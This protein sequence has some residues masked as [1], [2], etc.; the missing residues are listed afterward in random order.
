MTMTE[1]T[2]D[3]WRFRKGV[4]AVVTGGSRGI[5][6]SIVEELSKKGARILTCARTES[7][8][9]TK[10]TEW[11]SKGYQVDGVPADLSTASGRF[12]FADA[13]RTWL[14]GKPLDILVNNAGRQPPLRQIFHQYDDDDVL[15]GSESDELWATNFHSTFMLTS[16]CH[17]HLKRKKHGCSSTSSVVNIASVFGFT[18]VESRSPYPAAQAAVIKA[19]GDWAMDWGS[20]GIR[21][22]CVSPGLIRTGDESHATGFRKN[23]E[24]GYQAQILGATPLSRAGEP[25]EVAGLVTFLCLPISSFITGQVMCVDG[26]YSRSE[27]YNE[28][29]ARCLREK[30]EEI[31]VSTNALRH[32][33]LPSNDTLEELCRELEESSI[34]ESNMSEDAMSEDGIIMAA[35]SE[36]AISE[37]GLSDASSEGFLSFAMSPSY[38]AADARWRAWRQ[39]SCRESRE[40]NTQAR[41]KEQS[42]EK[43]SQAEEIRPHG[44]QEKRTAN[45]D[46]GTSNYK[47]SSPK[48]EKRK[49]ISNAGPSKHKSPPKQ[50]ERRAKQKDIILAGPKGQLREEKQVAEE[51][52]SHNAP[53]RRSNSS[54]KKHKSK[55]K[56]KSVSWDHTASQRSKSKGPKQLAAV[57]EFLEGDFDDTTEPVDKDRVQAFRDRLKRIQERKQAR[58]KM[59]EKSKT[60]ACIYPPKY[61]EFDFGETS[62]RS[63]DS[64]SE[65]F[66]EQY[67]VRRDMV[68]I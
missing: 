49:T 22:N 34:L 32:L 68:E 54:L 15:V 17:D 2:T 29:T 60:L 7:T 61:K 10:L 47:S 30:A 5:G 36:D 59:L 9:Q 23:T 18:S 1:P 67:L 8:L 52:R 63:N 27:Y 6:S 53:L 64:E 37:G 19:T 51:V 58:K 46:A 24:S 35:L 65:K 41:P 38:E 66:S 42:G 4:R 31:A 33:S 28:E 56:N 55:Q 43:R 44:F 21:V 50:Q 48:K 26:G 62:I 57:D 3:L 25:T 13:I 11:R 20:D 39:G 12:A 45:A 16:I 40:D 14:R